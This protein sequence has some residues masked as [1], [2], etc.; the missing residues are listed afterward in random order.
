MYL[1]VKYLFNTNAIKDFFTP[2]NY[3]SVGQQ[4]K[5]QSIGHKQAAIE[6]LAR[7]EALLQPI[8]AEDETV[9][10]ECIEKIESRFQATSDD[11]RMTMHTIVRQVTIRTRKHQ[12][13]STT[14]GPT[15][16]AF[17]EDEDSSD[18]EN[19]TP[20]LPD[21]AISELG[22]VSTNETTEI[23]SFC[24]VHLLIANYR[25]WIS[26][27]STLIVLLL[28]RGIHSPCSEV[29]L[30]I[31]TSLI[32]THSTFDILQTINSESSVRELATPTPIHKLQL[33]PADE[34]VRQIEKDRIQASLLLMKMNHQ[35]FLCG[36]TS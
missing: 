25:C 21:D 29:W 18:D 6:Q 28:W 15:Q 1:I 36:W 8:D 4:R 23:P 17:Q 34:I 30:K 26:F 33:L 3:I 35:T 22:L 13:K 5:Q 32:K 2:G 7:Q 16:L 10:K 20:L 24:G 11:V 14:L 31:S 27:L 12:R 9:V 19:V